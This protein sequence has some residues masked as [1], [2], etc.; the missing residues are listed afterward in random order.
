[1]RTPNSPSVFHLPG[2]WSLKPGASLSPLVYRLFIF[3]SL[4]LFSQFALFHALA[5]PK[6]LGTPEEFRPPVVV[7]HWTVPLRWNDQTRYHTGPLEFFQIAPTPS[8]IIVGSY[9][10]VLKCLDRTHGFEKWSLDMG[11]PLVNNIV[12]QEGFGYSV[13]QDGLLFKFGVNTGHLFWSESLGAAVVAQI[14]HHEGHL[15][16]LT[17]THELWK[18]NIK[19]H[20]VVW[21]YQDEIFQKVTL[22]GG[23]RPVVH[24]R[25]Y[26]V[27]GVPNGGVVA[28]DDRTGTRVWDISLPVKEAVEDVDATPILLKDERIVVSTSYTS[29]QIVQPDGTLVL[30]WPNG[31]PKGG[32][33]LEGLEK[34]P[35]YVQGDR[36]RIRFVSLSSGSIV[37]SI[38]VPL[39]WGYP[40]APVRLNDPFI[41]FAFSDG[42]AIALNSKTL[43]YVVV[44]RSGT[45]VAAQPFFEHDTSSLYIMSN[46]GNVRKLSLRFD[47]LQQMTQ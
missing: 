39:K 6:L 25:G 38:E 8:C 36:G 41:L 27:I 5:K 14:T 19:T 47:L 2:A 17:T 43:K 11:H 3:C 37:K 9:R 40:Q 35:L 23:T 18:Y 31:S 22:M 46:Y 21:K 7:E 12:T 33:V 29:T 15:Y 10:G 42:P 32:M 44:N 4:I 24:P 45:G 13:S 34:E 20:E 30:T 16:I 26:I 1:M 28:V